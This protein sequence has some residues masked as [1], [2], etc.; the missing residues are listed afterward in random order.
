MIL[1]GST[2]L[3]H[4]FSDRGK[5]VIADSKSSG[6][7]KGWYFKYRGFIGQKSVKELANMQVFQWNTFTN[8]YH[9]AWNDRRYADNP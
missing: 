5:K 7:N 3:I 8:E 9:P 1:N 4:R 2:Y 6:K